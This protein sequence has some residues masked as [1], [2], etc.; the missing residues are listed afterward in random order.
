M[1]EKQPLLYGYD[2][3]IVFF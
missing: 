1:R 3:A 2:C